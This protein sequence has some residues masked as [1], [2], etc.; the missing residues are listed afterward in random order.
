[1]DG[2]LQEIFPAVACDHDRPR[3]VEIEHELG[4]TVL[5]DIE[6]LDEL[7]SGLKAARDLQGMNFLLCIDHIVRIVMRGDSD[8][9]DHDPHLRVVA[10][11]EVHDP[12]LLAH[13]VREGHEVEGLVHI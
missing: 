3:G 10:G 7:D 2:R 8:L 9:T 13:T 1:V 11:I 5:V 4:R 6:S 12:Q